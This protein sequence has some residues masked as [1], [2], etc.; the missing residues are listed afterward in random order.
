MNFKQQLQMIAGLN[1]ELPAMAAAGDWTAAA[2]RVAE[3]QR[4]LTACLLGRRSGG[5]LDADDR[6]LIRRML[7]RNQRLLDQ[8]E[9]RRAELGQAGHRLQR[10]R[11]AMN[12]YA[13]IGA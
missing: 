11:H 9:A 4:L 8:A 5:H 3:C 13:R 1:A 10:N 12:T 7:E 2:D 6:E